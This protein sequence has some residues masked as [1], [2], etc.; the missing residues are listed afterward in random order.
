MLAMAIPLT[1]AALPPAARAALTPFTDNFDNSQP[2]EPG[3]PGSVWPKWPAATDHMNASTN[4]NHTP[5]GTT[6]VRQD[7][8]DPFTLANYHDFGNTAGG[9]SATVWVWDDNSADTGT[10]SRPVNFYVGLYGDA[11]SPTTDT[12]HLLLGLSPTFADLNTYGINSKSGG[13]ASTGVTR[14]AAIAGSADASNWIKLNITADALDAGG[15]V[16]F[17]I[18]DVLTGTASRAPG[19]DLRYLFMG[20]QSKNYEFFWYDDVNVTAVPEPAGGLAAAA[21]FA[22]A[23]AAF[24][25]RRRRR[26]PCTG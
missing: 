4:H 14:T 23:V 13:I 17:Y 3:F 24:G 9:V 21:V 18:N 8:Q 20:S 1:T 25:N 6:S 19:V 26:R 15:Q 22:P 11:A 2:G 12:D 10:A 7:P 16:R 5:A